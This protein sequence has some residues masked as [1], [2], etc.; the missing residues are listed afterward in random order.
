MN[1]RIQVLPLRGSPLVEDYLA[2]RGAAPSFYRGRP[3]NPAAFRA[4]LEE[5]SGRFDRAARERAA[6]AL[7]PTSAGAAERLRRF[8]E[9]GG[10]VVT[11]G[12]QT[13]LFTG[14]L[15]TVHKILTAI[16]LAEELERE[17]G[18]VV[19]PVFW[20]A[21][22][23]HDLDEVDHVDTVDRT[24]GGVVRL[25]VEHLDPRP[26]PMSDTS[27]GPNVEFVVSKFGQIVSQYGDV[28]KWITSIQDAYR[29]S[30]T[31]AGA[32][33][34]VVENLFSGFDLLLTDAADPA[35]KAAS[36][37]VLLGEAEHA[38]D[39]ETLLMDTTER[40]ERAGYDG[41]VA[42]LSDAANLFWHGPRGR[43]RLHRVD[44]GWEAREARRRFTDA[45]LRAAI[46]ADPV[47]FSPNVFLRPVV[48]SFVFPTLAYVAGPGEAAYFAQIG[49]L[50]EAFGIRMPIVFPRMS[51]VLVPE[52]ADA[53]LAE[54]GLEIADLRPPMHEIAQRIARERV[55][56]E[57]AEGF[58]ALRSS[59]VAGYAGLMNDVAAVDPTL[60]N[61]LGAERNRA[62]LGAGD[63]EQKVL[64]QIKRRDAGLL[65][66]IEAARAHLYPGGIPQERVLNVFPYLAAYGPNLLRDLAAQ[67]DVALEPAAVHA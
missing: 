5:V 49:P 8:V 11:T 53:A 48:E 61:A 67:A 24:R 39:H 12:Q 37:P 2:G 60:V 46:R 56:A 32:F 52:E 14:P 20:S 54:A 21:S 33:L 13:G 1:P 63:A 66:R 59:I 29:P 26:L 36:L 45:E 22:E 50:F 43:E 23:D 40:L 51:A 4:K 30:A 57:M 25:S 7:R 65:R 16:R 47:A 3:R 6:A 34:D 35:L 17:L 28:D 55:P 38:R 64:R 9:E 19:L 58:A 41:Q 44:G 18:V 15:Y 42:V 31:M 10:A 62:L 27:V